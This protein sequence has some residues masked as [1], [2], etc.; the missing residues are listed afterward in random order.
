MLKY[1]YIL[2]NSHHDMAQPVMKMSSGACKSLVFCYIRSIRDK[3][4]LYFDG[5]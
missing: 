5:I 2:V 4:W 1:G 3:C